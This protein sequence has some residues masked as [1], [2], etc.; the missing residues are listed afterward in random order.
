M[1]TAFQNFPDK[2][3]QMYDTTPLQISR[4]RRL[5]NNNNNNNNS[6]VWVRITFSQDKRDNL[7]ILYYKYYNE[8]IE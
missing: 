7:H 5:T 3:N 2:H 4:S 1:I 6:N 8:H